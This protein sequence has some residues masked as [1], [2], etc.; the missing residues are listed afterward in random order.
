MDLDAFYDVFDPSEAVHSLDPPSPSDPMY[1]AR[2]SCDV[3]S[4]RAAAAAAAAE[5]QPEEEDAHLD[6]LLEDLQEHH[7]VE[8]EEEQRFQRL[9][10]SCEDDAFFMRH[11]PIPSAVR[12]VR[13]ALR[14]Q[15]ETSVSG[16]Y[17]PAGAV[18]MEE[19]EGDDDESDEEAAEEEAG[20]ENSTAHSV[21]ADDNL[22]FD[23]VFT[24]CID[25]S[26]RTNDVSDDFL[27]HN[28]AN[29]NAPYIPDGILR[30]EQAR[31]RRF[32]ADGYRAGEK[33]SF[34]DFMCIPREEYVLIH[35]MAQ[36]IITHFYNTRFNNRRSF[37]EW[38][39]TFW[40]DSL[41]RCLPEEL[42]AFYTVSYS[43]AENH[44]FMQC[45]RD[46]AQRLHDTLDN[47]EAF[48]HVLI[49]HALQQE[50]NGG[51]ITGSVVVH[52]RNMRTLQ[53]IWKLKPSYIAQQTTL[54]LQSKY[55]ASASVSRKPL[56]RD[57]ATGVGQSG[58]FNKFAKSFYSQ[59][60]DICSVN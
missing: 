37:L 27:M 8:D 14:N 15:A 4:G 21:L 48:E 49:A 2:R 32:N 35:P 29:F 18:D 28:S 52:D 22:H 56:A 51:R 31:A 41:R 38:V 46:G 45:M 6:D 12:T 34:C 11:M 44:F 53:N 39:V 16:A 20:V 60:Q 36:T 47:I 55:L 59:N 26:T 7:A 24:E 25:V 13:N 5:T 58:I 3:A 17:I 50:V 57:D 23:R 19:Y 43:Q 33:C 9:V 1:D 40:N 42:A 30:R 54:D 10:G